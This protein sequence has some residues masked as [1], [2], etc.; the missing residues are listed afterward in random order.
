MTL[1][2][3]NAV[4]FRMKTKEVEILGTGIVKKLHKGICT[5]QLDLENFY[6]EP[7][8]LSY[9]FK[10]MLVDRVVYQ[11]NHLNS[12]E[13]FIDVPEEKVWLIDD[14]ERENLNIIPRPLQRFLLASIYS[15]PNE[16]HA[17]ES[18]SRV[19]QNATGAV[20]EKVPYICPKCHQQTIGKNW[21]GALFAKCEPCRIDVL[22]YHHI[23]KKPKLEVLTRVQEPLFEVA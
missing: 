6:F 23:A 19:E 8:R 5:I 17:W 12:Q 7:V 15:A 22:C 16:Y 1:K 14:P 9:S 11:K 13:L 21:G 3:F 20:F 18:L 2:T 4:Q 10:L